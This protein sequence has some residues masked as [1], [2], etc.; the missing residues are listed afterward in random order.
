MLDECWAT[1][2]AL[3]TKHVVPCAIALKTMATDSKCKNAVRN[4]RDRLC[5]LGEDVASA[6][7][8]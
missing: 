7:D 3:V 6:L 4:L 5:A 8:R 1:R 2:P